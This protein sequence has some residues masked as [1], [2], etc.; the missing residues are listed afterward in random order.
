MATSTETSGGY[1]ILTGSHDDTGTITIAGDDVI[2]IDTGEWPLG[3]DD[4]YIRNITLNTDAY[5]ITV[6]TPNTITLGDTVITEQQLVELVILLEVLKE[7]PAFAEKLAVQIAL[8]KI[9]K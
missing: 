7:D 9:A 4:D 8:N 5:P 2:T 3:Y 6:D 1:N